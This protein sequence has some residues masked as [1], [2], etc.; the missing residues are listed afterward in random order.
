MVHG[1][2]KE[3][4]IAVN[5]SITAIGLKALVN[6]YYPGFTAKIASEDYLRKMRESGVNTIDE[7]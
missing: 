1:A 5:S 2:S 6:K 4:W 7:K 3:V